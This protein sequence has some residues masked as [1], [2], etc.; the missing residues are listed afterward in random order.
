MPLSGIQNFGKLQAGFPLRI[1]AGMTICQGTKIDA[2]Q[3]GLIQE[4]SS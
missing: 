1:S 2:K 4:T 3:E